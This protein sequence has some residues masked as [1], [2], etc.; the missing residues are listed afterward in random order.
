MIGKLITHYNI[1]EILG[2]GGM[3]VVYKARDFNLD[4]LVAIKFIPPSVSA[5]EQSLNQFIHEAR[6]A[7][8]LDHPNICPVYEFDKTDDN[9]VFMVMPY[10]TGY[11]LKKIIDNRVLDQTSIPL[12]QCINITIQIAQG[13]ARAHKNNIIHRDIKPIS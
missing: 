3:G 11:T 7:A 10:C 4:R 13:L 1:L 2:E 6:T 9:R 8:I 12:D 5:N